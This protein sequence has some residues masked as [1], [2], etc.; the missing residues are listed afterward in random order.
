VIK[1]NEQNNTFQ[2]KR[3]KQKNPLTFVDKTKGH[4][5]SFFGFSGFK[6]DVLW[7]FL[8]LMLKR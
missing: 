2:N 8:V 4:P 6:V 7:F 5:H 3:I 1:A